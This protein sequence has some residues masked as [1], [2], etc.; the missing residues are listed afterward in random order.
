MLRDVFLEGQW[1]QCCRG[2]F[3]EFEMKGRRIL[4]T[5]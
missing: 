1:D 5:S 2:F 3:K 4:I